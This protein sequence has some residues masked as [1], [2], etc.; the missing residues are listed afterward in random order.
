VAFDTEYVW[1][2]VADDGAGGQASS[3]TWSFTTV[4]GNRP[5]TTPCSPSPPDGDEIERRFITLRWGCGDDPDGDRVRFDVYVGRT[6]T[7]TA[8]VGTTDY[9]ERSFGPLGLSEGAWYW[10]VVAED[11]RG[12]RTPGP[13]WSFDI[14]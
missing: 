4:A 5:P 2:V 12:A 14:D 10:R 11:E 13:V 1:R 9:D 3:A 7:P 6:P 8:Q